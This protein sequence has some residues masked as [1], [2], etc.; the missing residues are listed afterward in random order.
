MVV[1]LNKWGNSIGLR[2]PKPY[3]DL[4]GLRQGTNVE[5]IIRDDSIVLTPVTS[6]TQLAEMAAD[7]DLDLMISQITP[8]KVHGEIWN[9]SPPAGKEVW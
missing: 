8:D 4:L 2:I 7:I 9:D 6:S 1:Q 5:V 3:R